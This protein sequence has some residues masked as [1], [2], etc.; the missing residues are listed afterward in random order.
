MLHLQALTLGVMI[1]DVKWNFSL[2][3]IERNC[4]Q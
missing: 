3:G 1:D 2:D 4:I